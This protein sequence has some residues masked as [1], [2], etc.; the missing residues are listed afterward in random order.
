MY[1][2]ESINIVRKEKYGYENDISAKKKTAFK[3]SWFQKENEH[4][5]WKKGSGRQESKG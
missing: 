1:I 5:K 2:I 4:C 3:G